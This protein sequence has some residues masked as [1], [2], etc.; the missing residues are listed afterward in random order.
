MKPDHFRFAFLIAL[1]ALVAVGCG[2]KSP[3]EPA[4]SKSVASRT[5]EFMGKVARVV[6]GQMALITSCMNAHAKPGTDGFVVVKFTIRPSG[7]T[8]GPSITKDTI[9]NERLA[10][11][12]AAAPQYWHFPPPTDGENNVIHYKFVFTVPP[13][14]AGAPSVSNPGG[15]AAGAMSAPTPEQATP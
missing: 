1:A 6:N 8:Q 13:E 10:K 3:A 12:V 7:E 5:A 11:C 2:A 9:G 15:S 14:D 4:S